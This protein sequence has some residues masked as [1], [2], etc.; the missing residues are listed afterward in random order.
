MSLGVALVEASNWLRVE[1][2]ERVLSGVV[3]L[4]RTEL[5][6]SVQVGVMLFLVGEVVLAFDR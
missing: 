5:T 3:V 2:C 4:N 6:L 1:R